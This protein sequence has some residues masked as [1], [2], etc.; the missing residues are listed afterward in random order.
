M[1]WILLMRVG[2]RMPLERIEFERLK[3]YSKRYDDL[4]G[5]SS[6]YLNGRIFGWILE[7]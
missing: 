5:F 1:R 4:M 3:V 7:G 6:L 2:M